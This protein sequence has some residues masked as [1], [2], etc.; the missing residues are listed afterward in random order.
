VLHQKGSH[1]PAYYL[2]YPD[3]FKV[4]VPVCESSQLDKCPR[5]EIVNAYDNSILYTDYFLSRVIDFLKK[6]SD[7]FYTA[8]IYVSDHGESL[9]ENNIYLHGLPYLFAPEAQKHI[10]FILWFSEGFEESYGIDRLGLEKTSAERH[11]H[12]KLFDSVLGLLDITTK[13]YRPWQDIFAGVNK[14]NS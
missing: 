1:G 11:S 10:P 6:N 13:E 3:R 9:G 8:M 5:Q 2:R 14:T 12:D 7:R 4:F